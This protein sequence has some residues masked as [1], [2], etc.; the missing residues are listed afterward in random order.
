MVAHSIVSYLSELEDPRQPK[1]V[2]HAQL[3][4][5][6]IMVLAMLCGI[7]SLKGM[8]RFAKRHV[9]ELT[10]YIPLPR[11]KAP[12]YSTLQRLSRQLDYTGL[13]EQFNRWMEPLI[14]SE[15]V[16]VDG[17]SLASTFQQA[18]GE[19]QSFSSLVSFFGQRSQLILRVGKL[20]NEK[21]SEISLVQELIGTLHIERS[22]FTLDALHCQKKRWPR[23][24]PKATAISSRSKAISPS[25]AKP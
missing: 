19:K 1:G 2:R 13:C 18:P 15:T 16:S 5:L 11:G 24:L 7:T 25:C 17:K 3:S 8:A 14:E 9:Q 22:V 4:T 10:E 21:R 20:D 23:L 6:T 12:S